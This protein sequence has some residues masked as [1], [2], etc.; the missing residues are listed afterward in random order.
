MTG[1]IVDDEWID[2]NVLQNPNVKDALMDTAK[3]L[4]PIC[5]RLAIQEGCED[6]ADSLHLEQGVRPGTKSPTGI[7]R[8]YV[9][10]VAGSENASE[11]EYGSL[12]YPKHNFFNRAT[13]QL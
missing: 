7:K 9:N 3:R 8:P 5:Q 11:Q 10:V 12:R 4:L 1:A 2:R 6:F 13:A